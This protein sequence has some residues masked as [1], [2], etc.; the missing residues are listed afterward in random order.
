MRQKLSS[1]KP[2]VVLEKRRNFVFEKLNE[3]EGLDVLKPKAAFYIWPDVQSYF[4]RVWRGVKIETCKDF[5]QCLLESQS[6]V[7]VPGIEF[8][9]GG[10]LRI[11]YAL[12]E[13]RMGQAIQRL[14]RFIEELD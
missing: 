13:E 7:A 3:V 10:Y 1:K 6:V 4:G 2:L 5:S 14:Q 11:S 8:G 12:S 9:L